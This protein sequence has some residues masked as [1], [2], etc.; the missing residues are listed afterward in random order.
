MKNFPRIARLSTLGIVHHQ[1]FDY[2]FNAFRT[3][4]VGEGGAGKSMIADLLQLIFVGTAVFHSP[5]NSTGERKPNTMVLKSEGRGTDIAYAFLNIEVSKNIFLVIGIYL[6]SSGHSNMF[7]IQNGTDFGEES[8]LN[9]FGQLLGCEDFILENNILPLDQLKDHIHNFKGLTCESK[10]LSVYHKILFFNHILPIDLSNNRKTL[11]NFAKIIQA[12]SR[13]ALDISKSIKLQIFLFG[14]EKEKEFSKDFD[15]AVEELSGD[16]RQYEINSEEI[17]KLTRKQ[18]SLQEVLRSKKYKESC[19]ITFTAAKYKYTSFNISNTK[20]QLTQIIKN[21]LSASQKILLLQTD[22]NDKLIK[23]T[24]ELKLIEEEHEIKYKAKMFCEERRNNTIKYFSWLRHFNCTSEE[25]I[26]QHKDFQN[27]RQTINKIQELSKLL[28]DKKLFDFVEQINLVESKTLLAL[29]EIVRDLNGQLELKNRLKSFKDL[30]NKDSLAYWAVNIEKK[31]TLEQESII[32][33]YHNENVL[34]NL[35]ENKDFRYMPYPESF[36]KTIS[37]IQKTED[38]FWVDLNGIFEFCNYATERIFDT[39][40]KESIKKYFE[41][42]SRDLDKD[43]NSITENLSSYNTLYDIV[44]SLENPDSYIIAWNDRISIKAPLDH[45]AVYEVTETELSDLSILFGESNQIED[46]FKNAKLEYAEIDKKKVNHAAL[47]Q[48]L[49]REVTKFEKVDIPEIVADIIKKYDLKVDSEDLT[50]TISKEF[51]TVVDYYETFKKL[52]T[53]AIEDVRKLE[54]IS[55]IDN[56]ISQMQDDLKQLEINYPEITVWANEI[57][58]IEND[59]LIRLEEKYTKAN[60]EF[61]L[62]YNTTARDIL[63]EGSKRFENSGD[64]FGLCSAI[65]PS[66]IFDHNEMLDEDIIERINKYLRDINTKNQTLNGR[67]LQ[68]LSHIISMVDDEVSAQ[69]HDIRTIKTFFNSDDKEITGGHHVYLD[70]V[71]EGVYPKEWMRKFTDSINSDFSSSMEESLFTPSTISSDLERFPSLSEK[72]REAFYKCGGPRTLKPSIEQ[73]LNPKSYYDL[74]F[75][76][77]SEHGKKNDGSTS[78][79][80]AAIALLC[81]ARLT[82]LDRT[83]PQGKIREGIRFMAIDEAEGLGSNF[84]MLFKIAKANDYQILSLS[85]NPNKV[86]A[87]NQNIYLLHNNPEYD[88]IN[89]EPIPIFGLNQT[90]Q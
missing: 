43:I 4:F 66:E 9:G 72:M 29:G 61:L 87:Q 2:E 30:S 1:S 58:S 77:K 86:D 11:E 27:S 51:E 65:L 36:L 3:D 67:K 47:Q 78:Q 83:L 8:K 32:H 19:M 90:V 68:K 74:K 42:Q 69:L 18:E 48:N 12:F 28:K 89:Y 75:S 88:D 53:E 7:I 35:P 73:L 81:M 40:D 15:K 17:D 20:N 55:E 50:P 13:E 37:N 45:H 79:T 22:V 76:I 38:G 57:D 41:D 60:A 44:N 10:P 59:E 6:E 63:K 25:L 5:T 82:L 70:I 39:D 34:V 71:Y 31:L 49:E 21:G 62:R 33:K 52:H 64:F 16:V 14:D 26:Q 80:Y 54:V 56:N 46:D 84:D 24:G 23:L 85:I